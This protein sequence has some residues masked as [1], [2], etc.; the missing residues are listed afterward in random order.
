LPGV[1]LTTVGRV[2]GAPLVGARVVAGS[3]RSAERARRARGHTARSAPPRPRRACGSLLDPVFH[4]STPPCR[5][6]APLRSSTARAV[7]ERPDPLSRS[8][9][10]RLFGSAHSDPADASADP[11]SRPRP[12]ASARRPGSRAGATRLG[13]RPRTRDS[14]RLPTRTDRRRRAPARTRDIARIDRPRAAPARSGW[15]RAAT[16]RTL[17]RGSASPRARREGPGAQDPGLHLLQA[18]ALRRRR[19]DAEHHDHRALVP[20]HNPPTGGHRFSVS[21]RPPSIHLHRRRCSSPP[22]PP[23][24][25]RR[26]DHPGERRGES[27]GTSPSPSS[28]PVLTLT[29]LRDHLRGTSSKRRGSRRSLTAGRPQREVRPLPCGPCR[30]S[31]P[32]STRRVAVRHRREAGRSLP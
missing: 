1:A 21:P 2:V 19:R 12:S 11:G 31:S 16:S 22:A 30:G 4:G 15:T 29:R 20:P 8:C 23:L 32:A 27:G 14:K 25:R 5:T 3:T 13:V 10:L 6:S 7:S 9:P 18:D 28:P 24:R 26:E 17:P